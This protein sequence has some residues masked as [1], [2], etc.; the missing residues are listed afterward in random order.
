MS[1]TDM[2]AEEQLKFLMQ[3][4]TI[5]IGYSDRKEA[6]LD[7]EREDVLYACQFALEGVT[8]RKVSAFVPE[9]LEICGLGCG[10]DDPIGDGFDSVLEYALVLW[11][12]HQPRVRNKIKYSESLSIEVTL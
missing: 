5:Q 8:W 1:K 2:T 10:V 11:L 6:E 4:A 3:C 9:A 12:E 7:D